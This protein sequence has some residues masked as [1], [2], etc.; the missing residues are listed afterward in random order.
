MQEMSWGE[1]FQHDAS[2]CVEH[3]GDALER[4]AAVWARG[5]ETGVVEG[6]AEECVCGAAERAGARAAG[7][8]AGEDFTGVGAGA[9]REGPGNE[10]GHGAGAY[11]GD[12][13]AGRGE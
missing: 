10:R 5:D 7:G 3:A 2:W 9:D 1:V 12:S 11:A 4:G 13:A 6:G 8:G